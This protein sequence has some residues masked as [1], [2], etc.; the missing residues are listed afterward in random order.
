MHVFFDQDGRP[1]L[2]NSQMRWEVEPNTF[3]AWV[4][5]VNGRTSSATTWRSYA[6]QLAD[7]FGFCERIGLAWR[8]TSELNIA[9]Y[10]NV[11]AAEVSSHTGRALRRSTINYKLGVV[12]QFYRFA[13]RKGWI[14]ALPFELEASRIPYRAQGDFDPQARQDSASL[15]GSSLRLREPKEELQIPPRQDVRRFIRSFRSWRDQL[16]AEVMW[17]TG[18]RSKEVCVRY[19]W[20]YFPTQARL[21]R[22]L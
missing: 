4:S 21:K 16:I 3:L 11:L 13:H 10:R 14:D 20:M 15:G 7:W 2:L 5:A 22:R 9:T 1:F 6:Y 19:L 17:L 12:C 18:M 8:H